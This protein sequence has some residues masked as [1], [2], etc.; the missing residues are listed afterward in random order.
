MG[1]DGLRARK[2]RPAAADRL[3]G[4]VPAGHP[5]AGRTILNMVQ[6]GELV[7]SDLTAIIAGP[8][9]RY[10]QPGMFPAAA[11][12]QP[13]FHDVP[14]TP[15]R[16]EPYREFT[17]IYHELLR[18]VQAFPEL[19]NDDQLGNLLESGGDNF[20]I[21]YGMGGIGSEILANR[22]AVGPTSECTDCK[23]EEFFLSSWPNGD[24]AMIVD[25]PADTGCAQSAPN[26]F[27]TYSCPESPTRA[28]RA[29]YPDDPSNVY[30]GYL[31]DHT[32]F[33]ILHGGAD[34]HHLHHLHAHQWLRSP[35]SSSS[36]YLDSQAIGPG[37]AFTL[38]T[39]F[40]GGGNKN[41]DRRRLDLPLSLL[42]PLRRGHVGVMAGPRRV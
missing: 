22:L 20:A 1:R 31:W 2:P 27:T 30:H 34:L 11:A 3:S 4:G 42:P 17:I 19:Y 5:R 14:Q 6:D 40:N 38:E 39:V 16:R 12:D 23:Y 25:N 24:P 10:G 15:N 29:Y 33:R 13:V 35:N 18:S 37:S 21:N 8:S 36:E 26:D 28:T 41:L 32:K 9:D 7:H